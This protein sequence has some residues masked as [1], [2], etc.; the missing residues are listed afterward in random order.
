MIANPHLAE[1]TPVPR[2]IMT[3]INDTKER[4]EFF[5]DSERVR[6]YYPDTAE[7]FRVHP[8]H[9]REALK[10]YGQEKCLVKAASTNEQIIQTVEIIT[11]GYVRLIFNSER[12]KK[13]T[14]INVGQLI[15]LLDEDMKRISDLPENKADKE[16][17]IRSWPAGQPLPAWLD[18]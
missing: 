11:E 16:H 14:Y 15:E 5:V 17:Y 18:K 3:V 13:D 8:D 7:E 9:I 1:K 12:F 2:L 4:E 6:L 10:L